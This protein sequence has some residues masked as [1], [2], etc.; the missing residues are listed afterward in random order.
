M[1]TG[2]SPLA[3]VAKVFRTPFSEIKVDHLYHELHADDHVRVLAIWDIG[4]TP[5]EGRWII[6]V[7]LNTEGKDNG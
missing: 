2:H 3:P 4:A 7:D 6:R 1:S 5:M